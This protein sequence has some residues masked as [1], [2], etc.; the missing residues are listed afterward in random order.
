MVSGSYIS[1]Y[2]FMQ[3]CSNFRFFPHLGRIVLFKHQGISEYFSLFFH[4]IYN[5]KLHRKIFILDLIIAFFFYI[6]K[7]M[8]PHKLNK[9]HGIRVL[10][11]SII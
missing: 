5:L 4:N 7:F 8:N 11:E 2:L 6:I 3:Y 1:I 9:L 10:A